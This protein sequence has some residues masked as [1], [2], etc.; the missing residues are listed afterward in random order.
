MGEAKIDSSF[1][2]RPVSPA[3]FAGVA[4]RVAV[5]ES[6][7]DNGQFATGDIDSTIRAKITTRRQQ[8][9]RPRQFSDTYNAARRR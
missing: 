5:C 6:N 3:T 1:D 7:C 4:A 2:W 8:K 9:S